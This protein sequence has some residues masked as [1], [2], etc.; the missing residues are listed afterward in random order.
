MMKKLH[1]LLVFVLFTTFSFAQDEKKD[2]WIRVQSDDGEFSIEVPAKYGYFYDKVGTMISDGN[3][4][5]AMN[6]MSV[7]NSY[8]E[9]TLINFESYRTNQRTL[10]IL[11]EG[12][13]SSAKKQKATEGFSEIK[14]DGYKIKQLVVKTDKHYTVSQYFYSKNYIYILTASSRDGE[15]PIMKRFL[16]SLV[17]KPDSDKKIL[18]G[19][20]KFPA[21]KI[22]PIKYLPK[23][24]KSAKKDKTSPDEP[25]PLPSV[26]PIKTDSNVK[27]FLIISQP[28]ASF[29][30]EA[31]QNGEQG[32]VRLKV[33]FSE[34]GQITEIIVLETLRFGLLRNVV[35]AALRMKVIPQEKDD[36]P[37]PATKTIE[38]RFS[39]G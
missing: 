39:I 26:T 30:N 2:D 9:H 15:T 4:F 25:N 11:E 17:F 3:N 37:I 27:S 23:P 1:I 24:E 13:E 18:S 19:N 21:L 22:T 29:T 12:S 38:Y 14:K 7:F 16:D 35:F 33:S 34:S 32:A 36:K 20:S 28:R 5:Y 8:I 6:E 31:R 10:E